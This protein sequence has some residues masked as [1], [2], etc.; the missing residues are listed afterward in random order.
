MVYSDTGGFVNLNWAQVLFNSTLN[1]VSACYVSY[2]ASGN[3][4]SLDGDNNTWSN[5]ATLGSGGT[6]QNSQCSVNATTSSVSGSGNNLTLNLAVTFFS[7]FAGAK[8]TYMIAGDNDGIVS[9]WQTEGAWTVQAPPVISAIT[10]TSTPLGLSLS[11]DG[12]P[13][14]APCALQW[15]QGSP[16]TVAVATP[17]AG[18]A[19]VQYAFANWSDGGAPSHS[20][21]GPASATTYTA[22]F[23]TQYLMTTV[24]T[25]AT[26]G[27]ISPGSAF[28]NSG[29]SVPVGASANNSAQFS[30][31]SGALSGVATP[32]TLTMN[33]PSTVTANFSLTP[34]FTVSFNTPQN[35]YPL[36][37][38]PGNQDPI[39]ILV[40]S[41]A[42]FSGPVNLTVSGLPS[43]YFVLEG[44]TELFLTIPSSAPP[45]QYTVAVT[46]TSG[47][48][49]HT[50]QFTLSVTG[51]GPR[52]GV[53]VSPGI[54]T[55]GA[56]STTSYTA[57][58]NPS[59]GFTGTVPLS[60]SG[61]PAGSIV[62]FNPSS[63][64]TPGVSTLSVTVPSGTTGTYFLTIT[65]AANGQTSST[66]A[67]LVVNSGSGPPLQ[68]ITTFPVG[69]SLT[70]DGVGCMA[71]CSFQWTTGT[72][73]TIG[74]VLAQAG[75]AN[76]QYLFSN[77]LDLNACS[78]TEG[79]RP[80]RSICFRTG[81][82][83]AR[84]LALLPH[85]RRR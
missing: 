12:I 2:F 36:S 50:A 61:Q 81:W 44:S 43:N 59:G 7:S 19:G 15:I 20:I 3:V 66:S 68:T 38:N 48:L 21:S 55:V 71:P 17:Q 16:H 45:T 31:F 33:G 29:A 23:T 65:G 5:G 58:V 64:V 25:P 73:H 32:Q 27:T 76:T 1:G 69:L 42:G 11:A 24:V 18:A 34:D 60:V 8:S 51:P 54:Q 41:V 62:S 67:T 26:A 35:L 4:I 74:T 53:S 63:V 47:S 57:I 84:L 72:G 75:A 70:V 9:Q 82:T 30:G 6:L 37:I 28:F 49:S 80:I 79:W 22:N 40:G 83:A 14:T 39:G 10:V 46:G 78:R 52:F 77:W 85:N 13:C 56:G